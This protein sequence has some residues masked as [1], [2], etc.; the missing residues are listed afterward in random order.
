MTAPLP[1]TYRKGK[2]L[3]DK[4]RLR[5]A[6]LGN[7]VLGGL[8]IFFGDLGAT[9]AGGLFVAL[10]LATW[11]VSGFGGVPFPE[12]GPSKKMIVVVG[13]LGYLVVVVISGLWGLAKRIFEAITKHPETHP[14]P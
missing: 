5:W 1:F 14:Q 13:S 6:G 3:V 11:I 7:L 10:G 8:L 12:L 4:T 9:V 2:S